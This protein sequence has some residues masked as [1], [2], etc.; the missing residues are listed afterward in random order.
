VEIYTIGFT[1]KSAKEFFDVLRKAGIKSLVDIRL[2]NASQ[3]SGFT[4]K[5]DLAFFLEE[6]CRAE[7]IH[8]ARTKTRKFSQ[9]QG[10]G[11]F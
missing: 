3:L 2:N 8:S 6:I 1:R 7:Y 11:E 9:V 5:D 4:K 10:G